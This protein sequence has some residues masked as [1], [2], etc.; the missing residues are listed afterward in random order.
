[1]WGECALAV[2]AALLFLAIVLPNAGRIALDHST[3]PPTMHIV[4]RARDSLVLIGVV[5]VP[6]VLVLIGTLRRSWLATPGWIL[7][8]VLLGMAFTG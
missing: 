3:T 6:L 8:A 1:M 2:L 5:A 7:L 4:G